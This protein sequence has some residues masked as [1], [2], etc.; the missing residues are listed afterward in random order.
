MSLIANEGPST[1]SV[2]VKRVRHREEGN[3]KNR[4]AT[5]SAENMCRNE[6]L[7]NRGLKK[8]TARRVIAMGSVVLFI[9]GVCV[10]SHTPRCVL[11]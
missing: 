1:S 3:H 8:R 5:F 10:F 11:I 4:V 6:Y 7:G 9:I 2:F